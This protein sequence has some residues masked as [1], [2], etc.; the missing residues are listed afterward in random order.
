[1]RNVLQCQ[2][3]RQR[4]KQQTI[5][6]CENLLKKDFGSIRSRFHMRDLVANQVPNKN[7]SL[8]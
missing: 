7:Y 2:G 3:E 5:A 1:M 6:N 4:V 8:I